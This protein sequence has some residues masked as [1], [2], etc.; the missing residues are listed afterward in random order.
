MR[1]L[2]AFRAGV[3]PGDARTLPTPLNGV[4]TPQDFFFVIHDRLRG[5]YYGVDP[6]QSMGY[7]T[8]FTAVQSLQTVA[9]V[10]CCWF[11]EPGELHWNLRRSGKDIEVEILEF[12]EISFPGPASWG[13]GIRVQVSYEMGHFCQ[14]T[15]EFARIH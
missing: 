14:T 11:Q 4:K 5:F 10:D 1:R 3:L 2:G 12:R 15:V 6:H 13:T 9:A 8:S 7:M